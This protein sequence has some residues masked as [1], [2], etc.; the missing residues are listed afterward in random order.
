M[1]NY[2]K[3]FI[4]D[5]LFLL[6][7]SQHGIL[8]TKRVLKLSLAL[9]K[10]LTLTPQDTKILAVAACYHDIGRENE[11]IEPEHGLKSSRKVLRLGLDKLHNLSEK[12]LDVVLD[13][14]R[15][16]SLAD[17][18]WTDREHLL[19]YQILK[20]ADALDRLRF[21]DLDPKYL[22]LP[23]SKGLIDMEQEILNDRSSY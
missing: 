3:Q 6:P 5:N 21:D 11:N 9:A 7:Y 14:I 12:D 17:Y 4:K 19:L 1:Y 8:H 2:Y 10:K 18:L 13:L 20:D 15:F 23:E 22:R 16:H